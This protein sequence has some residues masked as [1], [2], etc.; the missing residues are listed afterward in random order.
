MESRPQV[1]EGA[2]RLKGMFLE[3]PGTRL[4]PVDAA[5]LSGLDHPLCEQILGALEDALFL[6]RANDGR[7]QRV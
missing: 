3:V 2:Q 4:T 6:K 1:V 5:R 7:Y